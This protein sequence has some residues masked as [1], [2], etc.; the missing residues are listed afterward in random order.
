MEVDWFFE[1]GRRVLA[2]LH[3]SKMFFT[4][5]RDFG[6]MPPPRGLYWGI[7]LGDVKKGA[8]KIDLWAFD[9]ELWMQKTTECEHLKQSLNKEN[10]L[11]ILRLKSQLWRDP[12]YR[13]EVTS[14]DLYDAVLRLGC[15]SVAEFWAHVAGRG[16]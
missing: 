3:P 12:R 13:D 11:T 2:A 14:A 1:L 8:W 15:R 16:V 6:D 9:H 4:N 10:R 5:G 7:R